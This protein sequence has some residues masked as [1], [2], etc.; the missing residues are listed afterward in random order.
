MSTLSETEDR[1]PFA[2]GGW[3]G[4]TATDPA[5]NC[6]GECAETG[7][8][9]AAQ[10][11]VIIPAV[12]PPNRSE[13]MPDGN[14]I[15]T[16]PHKLTAENPVLAKAEPRS[17]Q[18]IIELF[19]EWQEAWT[20]AGINI[21]P[22][23]IDD[24][25]A[26]P[27]AM[28]HV[29]E[30]EHAIQEIPAA[31]PVGMAIKAYMLAFVLRGA[32]AGSGAFGIGGFSDSEYSPSGWLCDEEGWL[33][34]LLEDAMRF[35]PE[36]A[37]FTASVVGAPSTL[38]VAAE[39]AAGID[40]PIAPRAEPRP[41]VERRLYPPLPGGQRLQRLFDDWVI[42]TTGSPPDQLSDDEHHRACARFAAGAHVGLDTRPHAPEQQQQP[43]QGEQDD[44][45]EDD[46]PE[47]V[48][49]RQ[50]PLSEVA[51]AAGAD[52]E[53]GQLFQQWIEAEQ[54]YN[55]LRSDTPESEAAQDEACDLIH[56]FAMTPAKGW[57]GVGLK[58]YALVQLEIGGGPVTVDPLFYPPG[59]WSEAA[60]CSGL[61]GALQKGLALDLRRLVPGL[62]PLIAPEAAAC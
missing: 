24:G 60:M 17:D 10:P 16:R 7:V 25:N 40:A 47:L 29:S 44:E 28:E 54:R 42:E 6:A 35:C 1:D 32:C 39:V 9:M 49:R 20:A 57:L 21:G 50:L 41:D 61:D 51:I 15:A 33:K 43:V 11:E 27:E 38:P 14:N 45:E 59:S 22:D 62:S 5:P 4:K 31:G 53:I 13:T 55:R 37:P 56:E 52:T 3:S 30:I 8:G 48:Q 34:T 19:R 26:N 46:D 18:R 2:A 58:A 12:D 36:L 23:G